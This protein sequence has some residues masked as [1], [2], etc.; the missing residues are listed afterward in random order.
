MASSEVSNVYQEFGRARFAMYIT[1]PW[2]MGEFAHRLPPGI[3]WATAPMPGPDGPG[4]SL[5]GGSSLVIFRGTSHPAEAWRFLE[6][7]S[8]P[9]VQLR[10]YRLTGDL[11]AVAQAWN[12]TSLATNR[13]ARA[14]WQQ[15]QRVEPLPKVPEIE[16]ICIKV[17]DAVE[18]TVRGGVPQDVALKRL[19]AQVDQILAKRRWL[20]A[21]DSARRA[22]GSGKGKGAARSTDAA[23]G[24]GTL[25]G[26]AR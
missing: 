9:D 24:V 2:Q 1:G 21:Q 4:V 11:P 7:L 12:D 16:D 19:D 13:Y 10:F 15:L 6:Y 23:P 26:G 22:Q 17:Q 20:L 25:A 3:P 5:A 8:R 14:F 18:S